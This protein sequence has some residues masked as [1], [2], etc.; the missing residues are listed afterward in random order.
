[1]NTAV[2]EG[3]PKDIIFLQKLGCR[4]EESTKEEFLKMKIF[5]LLIKK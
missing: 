5:T 3:K 2:Q 4:V 1:L